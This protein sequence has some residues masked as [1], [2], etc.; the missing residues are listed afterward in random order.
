MNVRRQKLIL[1]RKHRY[2]WCLDW[3]MGDLGCG[4]TNDRNWSRHREQPGR[5][6]IKPSP[7]GLRGPWDRLHHKAYKRPKNRTG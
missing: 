7:K 2:I 4:A 3:W 1:G 6:R 5:P